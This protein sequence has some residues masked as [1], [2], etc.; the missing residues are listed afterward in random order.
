MQNIEEIYKKYAKIVYKYVFCL[1]GN[2]DVTEEI[3]QET[4]LVAVKDINK[5]RCDCKISTWLC[6]ISKYIWYKRLKKE[7]RLKEVSLEEIKDNIQFEETL[8]EKLYKKEIKFKILKQVQKLDKEVKDVMYLRLL[9]NFKFKEIAQIMGK[10]VDWAKVTFFRGK[11][12]IKEG[13]KDEKCM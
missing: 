4:F 13:L 1:T 8:E 11:K 6:Q 7:K 12:K 9:G 10:S 2:K 5:F 3:V